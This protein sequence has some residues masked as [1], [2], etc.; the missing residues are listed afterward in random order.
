[1]ITY[2]LALALVFQMDSK[3]PVMVAPY[4]GQEACMVEAEH[5]NQKLPDQFKKSGAMY[6]CLKVE[7]PDA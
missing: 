7:Y 5:R 3:P 1:M 2:F 4:K 6:V